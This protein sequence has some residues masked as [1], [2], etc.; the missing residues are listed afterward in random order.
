MEEWNVVHLVF[1]K[2]ASKAGSTEGNTSAWNKNICNKRWEICSR[3]NFERRETNFWYS[4]RFIAGLQCYLDNVVTDHVYF[5]IEFYFDWIN[6]DVTGK[7]WILKIVESNIF[8]GYIFVA[9]NNKS[10]EPRFDEKHFQNI[11]HKYT[12]TIHVKY[13]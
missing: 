13:L 4:S 6:R 1:L 11:F 10:D 5:H 8:S 9:K 2:F 12:L 7:C 3:G